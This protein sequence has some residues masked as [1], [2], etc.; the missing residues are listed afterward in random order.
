MN[1][2][3]LRPGNEASLTILENPGHSP[4]YFLMGVVNAFV[5]V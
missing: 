4:N 5:W 2:A 3:T 1:I